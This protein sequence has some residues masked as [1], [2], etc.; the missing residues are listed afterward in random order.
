MAKPP[1]NPTVKIILGI[2]GVAAFGVVSYGAYQMGSKNGREVNVV[3]Q[4]TSTSTPIIASTTIS[5]AELENEKSDTE[6][7]EFALRS[8]TV[9]SIPKNWTITLSE[10]AT[11]NQDAVYLINEVNSGSY[12]FSIAEYTVSEWLKGPAAD[13][14]YVIDAKERA[15]VVR[16][17]KGVH[18]NQKI[19][20]ALNAAFDKQAGEI[21]GYSDSMRVGR[22]YL[23]SLDNTF[24]GFSFYNTYGQA[25]G[26][27]PVYH[28]NVYNPEKGII[29]AAH[30]YDFDKATEVEEINEPV[31]TALKNWET[32]QS[33]DLTGLDTAGH[34]A[35]KDLVEKKP[36]V[37]LSFGAELEAVDAVIKSAR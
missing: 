16:I 8:G 9:I 5:S 2:L 35:F 29:L 19:T 10:D 12:Q 14:G 1:L 20:S 30:Y 34:Q 21:F 6:L 17:L 11:S 33:A 26:V 3:N 25:P 32:E 4:L 37:T 22:E 13:E 15:E 31:F 7:K 18:D 27:Y 23:A 28:L 24:R 36:R